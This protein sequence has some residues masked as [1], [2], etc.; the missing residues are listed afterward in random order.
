MPDIQVYALE[1]TKPFDVIHTARV[2][3]LT[4]VD[5]NF[6]LLNPATYYLARYYKLEIMV[7]TVNR[8]WMARFLR[9]LYPRISI[10]TDVPDQMQ[11]LRKQRRNKGK[12]SNP[13]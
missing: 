13:V 11:F 4:G 7:Y 8:P 10:T 1:D 9:L 2:L 6:W 5:L 3:G 12:T